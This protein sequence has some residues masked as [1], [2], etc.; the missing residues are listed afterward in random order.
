MTRSSNGGASSTGRDS[1]G[2]SPLSP[3]KQ[4]RNRHVGRVDA[5]PYPAGRGLLF[6]CPVNAFFRTRRRRGTV[7]RAGLPDL[8]RKRN[9]KRVHSRSITIKIS[10][11]YH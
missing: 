8:V 5:R 2:I 3:D 6:P 1:N 9:A 7:R 4:C 10:F 11:N